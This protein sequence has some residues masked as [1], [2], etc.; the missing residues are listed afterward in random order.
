MT[1]GWGHF[2]LYLLWQSRYSLTN[3]ASPITGF[4]MLPAICIEA[5]FTAT[6][7]TT[8][9]FV[10]PHPITR[11]IGAFRRYRFRSVFLS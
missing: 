5:L 11:R 8:T 10:L 7:P 9:Y 4:V 2:L 1:S 6:V 3:I